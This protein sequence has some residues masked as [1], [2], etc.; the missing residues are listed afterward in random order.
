LDLHVDILGLELDDRL[1]RRTPSE[2]AGLWDEF[3]PTGRVSV[4]LDVARGPDGRPTVTRSRVEGLDLALV[5]KYFRYPLDHVGGWVSRVG[6]AVGPAQRPV[7]G[8]KPMSAP[9]TIDDPGPDAH[10]VLDFRGEALPIA[11]TLL[12]AMPPDVRAVVDQFHPTGTVQGEARV[13]R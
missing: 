11:R 9:R 7:G 2:L 1:R 13:E 4:A 12:D 8:N 3:T 6:P 5:Y 10:V